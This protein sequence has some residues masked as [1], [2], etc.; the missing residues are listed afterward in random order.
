MKFGTNEI[1]KVYLG[2]TELDKLYFGTSEVYS[3]SGGFD[4]YTLG[5]WHFNGNTDNAVVDSQY[6]FDTSS[7]VVIYNDN[8]KFGQSAFINSNTSSKIITFPANIGTSPF[9]YDF[10]INHISGGSTMYIG[11]GDN[12]YGNGFTVTNN[13]LKVCYGNPSFY[14][15]PGFSNNSWHHIAFEYTNGHRY[16]YYDGQ[17]VYSA[18]YSGGVDKNCFYFSNNDANNLID[19]LRLSNI[20]RY[21]GNNFTPSNSPYGD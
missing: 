3:K 2:T 17:L 5:V 18:T 21:N 11:L 7:S 4:E 1:Q 9:C 15:V 8:G 6:Q 10:W 19:E 13:T 16:W 20:G 12:Y 14:T